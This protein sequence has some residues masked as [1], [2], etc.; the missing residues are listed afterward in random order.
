MMVV[1]GNEDL[2]GGGGGGGL[3][4]RRKCIKRWGWVEKKEE[5]K[6]MAQ[7]GAPP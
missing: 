7:V 3:T 5:N 1:V 2:G 4:N 6:I